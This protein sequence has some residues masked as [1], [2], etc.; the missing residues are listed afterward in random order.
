MADAAGALEELERSRSSALSD[1]SDRSTTIDDRRRAGNEAADRAGARELR[2]DLRFLL[3]ADDQDFVYYLEARG[4]GTVPARVAD[5]RL[6]HRPRGAVRSLPHGRPDLGHAGRRRVVRLRQGPARHRRRRR[7]SR[8]VGVRLR[9]QALLYLPRRMPPPKSPAFAEAVARETIELLTRSRGRAFVLFTSYRVLRRAAARRDGAALS[10][11][12][13]GHGAAL[14]ADRG[15]PVDA[16]RG[17][18]GDLE[19]LAGR[20]RRRARR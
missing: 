19:L 1:S 13:A 11:P 6:A 15:V 7:T 18:A 14:G 16:E 20:G 3:R 5:R 9:A 8:A 17:A 4:R 12:R 10:D 2:Q